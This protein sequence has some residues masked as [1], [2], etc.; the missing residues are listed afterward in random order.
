MKIDEI[1]TYIRQEKKD[2]ISFNH[3]FFNVR[4]TIQT[5]IMDIG[6][7]IYFWPFVNN[8]FV[9]DPQL[10]N[11]YKTAVIQPRKKEMLKD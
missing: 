11:S 1:E 9:I 5:C 6:R 10:I 2:E 3:H 8:A 4:T 7:K